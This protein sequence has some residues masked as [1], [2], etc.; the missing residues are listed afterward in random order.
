MSGGR[1][2]SVPRLRRL[3][4]HVLGAADLDVKPHEFPAG[5][6]ALEAL[7]GDEARWQELTRPPQLVS[8]GGRRYAMRPLHAA[9]EAGCDGLLLLASRQRPP[10][11]RD[12]WRLAELVEPLLRRREVMVQRVEVAAFGLEG[13][14]T[15][16]RQGLEQFIQETR[17][18]EVVL[19]LGGGAT[20]AFVGALLGLIQAGRTP[21]LLKLPYEGEPLAPPRELR[22][23]VSLVPWLVRAHQYRVLAALAGVEEAERRAW[24]TLAA[25]QALDWQALARA[26]IGAAEL[27]ELRRRHPEV[28]V[29]DLPR[30]LPAPGKEPTGEAEW[31]WYRRALQ[32]SLLVRAAGD[33]RSALYLGR[34][35]TEAR[36]LELAF[37][38]PNRD[39]AGLQAL[40]QGKPGA[41]AGLL[42]RPQALRQGPVRDLLENQEVRKLCRLGSEAS[43]G[44]LREDGNDWRLELRDHLATLTHDLAPG[45]LPPVTEELLALLPVGETGLREQRGWSAEGQAEAALRGLTDHLSLRSTPSRRI[46]LRLVASADVREHAWRLRARAEELRFGSVAVIEVDPEDVEAATAVIADRL[47]ADRD[48]AGCAEVL[49]VTGPGTKVM[50]LA[51][52]VA[53][54]QWATN[55][56]RSLQVGNL[57]ED[58]QRQSSRL[59]VDRD[60]VLLRLGPDRVVDRVLTSAL[61]ELR[62]DTARRVL[63]LASYRWRGLQGPVAELERHLL[64]SRGR[65][66]EGVREAQAWFPA[67]ARAFADL[68]ESDPWRAVYATCA[69]AEAAWPSPRRRGGGYDASSWRVEGRPCGQALWRVRNQSPFGHRVWALPPSAEEVRELIEGV[70]REVRERPP[71][72]PDD[73]QPEGFQPDDAIVTALRSLKA[74]VKRVA[75]EI[76]PR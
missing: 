66:R 20:L 50:N 67:R 75:A 4:V 23:E 72:G 49:L 1:A 19:N 35:W 39:R 13:F 46:H 11:P 59:E 22:L 41:L 74:D 33:R 71:G 6:A 64:G 16:A 40:R 28:P 62:L 29:P 18:D 17:A 32:A 27:K 58:G 2:R 56:A 30:P 3:G 37:Q 10:D 14:R 51:M 7:S 57:R 65:G 69:A 15:A 45:A 38:D 54:G 36:V 70:I 55:R 12:T 61:R 26:E 63:E 47:E 68:A 24:R 48:L 8:P 52:V 53:G 73:L 76:G 9:V 31:C 43:H 42:Q 25:A 21:R 34:P 60:R 44:K 5:L